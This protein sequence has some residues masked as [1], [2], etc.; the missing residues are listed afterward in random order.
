MDPTHQ[1]VKIQV[2][3]DQD[4]LAATDELASVSGSNRSAF[5]REALRRQVKR[6]R[7]Q[8]LE[9]RER[10]SFS[11]QPETDREKAEF[12]DWEAGQAWED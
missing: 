10:K 6:L 1:L 12:E 7:I 9:E 11:E 4:L 3:I 2:V 8:A 5:V